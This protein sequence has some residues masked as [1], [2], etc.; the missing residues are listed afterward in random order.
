M[1]LVVDAETDKVLGAAMSGPDAAEIMQVH[2]REVCVFFF[3]LV[4]RSILCL[5]FYAQKMQGIA[6]ALK[7]GATKATFDSTVSRKTSP[8]LSCPDLVFFGF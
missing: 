5:S 8:S 7:A 4:I 3:Q 1:K 2:I 6:V